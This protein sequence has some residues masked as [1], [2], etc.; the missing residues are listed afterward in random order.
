MA[1][2]AADRYPDAEAMRD[3]L[4][5]ALMDLD[6]EPLPPSTVKLRGDPSEV[7]AVGTATRPAPRDETP[8]RLDIP[9]AAPDVDARDSTVVSAPDA[10]SPPRVQAPSGPPRW[11][12]GLAV[13][14]IVGVG[15]YV[16]TRSSPVPAPPARPT[17][18]TTSSP[19]ETTAAV[20]GPA[21]GDRE[22]AIARRACEVWADALSK[23]QQPDGRFGTEAHRTPS[24]WTTGQMLAGL[25]ASHRAC[26]KP[27]T[28]PLMK[29]LRALE[30]GRAP[31]GWHGVGSD[32]VE[33]PATAWALLAFAGGG[34][35]LGDARA[36]NTAAEA[37]SLLLAAQTEEGGFSFLR[38]GPDGVNDYTT[39]LATWALVD[40]EVAS[41]DAVPDTEL[42]DAL[43]RLEDVL[44]HDRGEPPLRRVAGLQEQAIWVWLRAR[45]AGL[46][47]GR[48]ADVGATVARDLIERCQLDDSDPRR[49]TRPIYEDGRTYLDRTNEGPNLLT[50]WHPWVVT[51]ANALHRD[52]SLEIAAE[53]RAALADIAR[54][55]LHELEAGVALIATAPGYKL[56]EYLIAVSDLLPPAPPK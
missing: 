26:G 19:V 54:W 45:A 16:L 18:S 25:S 47:Q 52:A 50:L 43:D 3:A 53:D 10:G 9:S 41:A 32:R 40:A 14:A 20:V 56:S 5:E 33:T 22:R 31:E 29:G 55:G 34:P 21:L 1:Y 15:I 39:V 38:D 44:T 8:T 51:A 36:L 48:D 28:S 37:A 30:T 27:G 23:H 24:G 2:D 4:D 46:R 6:G 35:A 7:V 42:G 49:C 17:A 11:A 12:S 13:A